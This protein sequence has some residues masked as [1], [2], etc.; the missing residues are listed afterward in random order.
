M[1]ESPI[2]I[3]GRAASIACAA[4]GQITHGSLG[5]VGEIHPEVL[6]NFGLEIPVTAFELDLQDL[7]K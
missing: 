7:V 4:L 2:F 1:A 6:N 3:D 5:L